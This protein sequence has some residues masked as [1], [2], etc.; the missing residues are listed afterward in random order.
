MIDKKIY[1]C[2]F[3]GG[4][5]S[6]LN[7]RCMESWKKCCPDYEIIEIN[8]DN[9]DVNMTSYSAEAY[10]HGNWSYV[11]NAARLYYLINFGGFYLDTDVQLI[12]SLDDFREFDNGFITEFESGQPDSGVL[13][14]SAHSSPFY[15]E[16]YD[17]LVPGTVLHKEFIQVL[18]RDYDI[19]GE[20]VITY[21]DGFTVLG[22]EFFPS[23]RINLLTLNT[24]GI[25]YFENTWT[26]QWRNITDDFYPFP[27]VEAKILSKVVH[28]DK[29]FEVSMQIKNIKKKWNDSDMI[30]KMCYFFNPKVV[31]LFNKDFEAERIEYN[32]DLPTKQTITPT[33]LI[34]TWIEEKD[35]DA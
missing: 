25:H 22:E 26:K 9:Y 8:E 6:E 7:K 4:E 15:E 10:E 18:Y 21:P 29:D 35:N 24:V 12:Q 17:R 33:G 11:S 34:V 27:R 14:C 2:W 16:V 5:K 28:R 13:G 3:G 1:Y 19:Y 31:K 23:V 30:G 20:S 32:K